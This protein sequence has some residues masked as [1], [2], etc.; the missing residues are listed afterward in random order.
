MTEF[1]NLVTTTSPYFGSGMISRFSALCRRDMRSSLLRPFRAVLRAALLS[2]LDALRVEHAAQHV[3]AHPGQVLDAAAA[4]HD[5]RVL[6]KIV[7]LARDVADHLVTV[8]QADLGDLPQ[9][10]VR[11]LRSGRVD[12]RAH[13]PLLRAG[14]ERRDRVPASL[15]RP[16]LADQLTDRRHSFVP[17]SPWAARKRPG[18]SPAGPARPTQNETAPQAR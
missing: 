18:T 3:V 12:A 15:R 5:D 2:V 16:R 11:L 7:A 6:L 10:R 17:S 13:A 14:L 4:D 9:R 8:R 1:M